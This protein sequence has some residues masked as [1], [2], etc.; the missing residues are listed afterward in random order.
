MFDKYNDFAFW[1]GEPPLVVFDDQRQANK[2]ITLHKVQV[3][4][5]TRTDSDAWGRDTLLEERVPTLSEMHAYLEFISSY[6]KDVALA[7]AKATSLQ[8]KLYRSTELLKEKI[9]NAG[10]T[11]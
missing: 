2:F 5:F 8:Q 9:E 6:R 3:I 7:Y 11:D 4:Q 10:R 1:N